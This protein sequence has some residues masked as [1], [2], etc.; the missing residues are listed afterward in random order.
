M[1]NTI[2]V[3]T[4]TMTCRGRSV[5]WATVAFLA[6]LLQAAS[7]VFAQTLE[8]ISSAGVIKIGY[9]EDARPFSFKGETGEPSG[10]AIDLCREV[11]ADVA[12]QLKLAE[13][14]ID[15]L[16]VSP[17]KEKGRASSR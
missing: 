12:I 10:F 4:M 16:P 14:S 2:S 13:L 15:Y 11:V 5:L 6:A 1:T 9:R 8:R 17:L 7:P 3:Q